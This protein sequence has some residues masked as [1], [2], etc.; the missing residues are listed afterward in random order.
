MSLPALLRCVGLTLACGLGALACG[1][2]SPP[3]EDAARTPN[4]VLILADDLG[5]GD[6]ASHGGSGRT[7]ALTA[8]AEQGLQLDQF[9]A[10]PLCTPSR[11]GLLTGRSP[12]ALGLGWS[13]LRPWSEL[14]LPS[15]ADTLPEA[16]QRAGYRTAL[17]GKWHLGHARPEHHPLAHGFDHFYGFLTG[18]IDY[19]QRQ[20][21]DG[22]LDWQRNGTTVE[23]EGY[24]TTLLTDEA[25]ALIEGHDF[26][27]APLFLMLSHPAPHRPMQAPADTLRSLESIEDQAARVYAAMLIE[28]DRGI[29]R[30]RQALD[31]AG[32]TASTLVV[33]A[34]DNGAALNL[35]G[36]NGPLKGGK[37]VVLQ[38][39]LRVPAIVH[40]PGQISPGQSAAFVSVLDLAPSLVQLAGA[41]WSGPVDGRDVSRLWTDPAVR[42]DPS[43]LAATSVS[44]V[45]HN[46]ARGQMAQ[47]AWPWKL[48]RRV[49]RDGS[50]AREQLFHLGEDPGETKS[51]R[52]EHPEIADALRAQLEA[53]L[54]RDPQGTDLDQ[55]PSWDGDL[56][57][58]WQAP[59]EWAG[60]LRDRG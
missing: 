1:E 34:S 33:F 53:A 12:I 37:S 41:S 2:V 14:G 42:L 29:A 51:R 56:P 3:L 20:S 7:P 52:Q 32:Q 55:L 26:A 9:H 57:P 44:F 4:I 5:Y 46:E 19:F 38:G 58:N 24:V 48:V 39:G 47:I 40:W 10:F 60:A 23:E 8:L 21:R 27:A 31:D 6:L 30:V 22:G 49:A 16:L 17:L 43:S 45:A 35:G 15:E 50:P 28:L 18:A 36:D 25:V 59:A 54:M 11:A 13:P